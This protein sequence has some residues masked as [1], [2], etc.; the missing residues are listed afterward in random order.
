MLPFQNIPA[1]QA[2]NTGS[3]TASDF[4]LLL[5][6]LFISAP[7]PL[8]CLCYFSSSLFSPSHTSSPPGL[9]EIQRRSQNLVI[10]L[11]SDDGCVCVGVALFSNNTAPS[12]DAHARTHTHTGCGS[13]LFNHLTFT[14]LPLIC[15]RHNPKH[16]AGETKKKQGAHMVCTPFS[17]YRQ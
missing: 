5:S 8:L 11:P 15:A 14:S 6:L 10:T 16:T 12:E 3:T 1:S 9:I 4:N 7:L 2:E 13:Q 17:V